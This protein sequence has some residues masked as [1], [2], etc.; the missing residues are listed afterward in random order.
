MKREEST[1]RIGVITRREYNWLKSF[2]ELDPEEQKKIEAFDELQKKGRPNIAD[3]SLKSSE[4]KGCKKIEISKR[5]VWNGFKMWYK[6]ET[7]REFV[8]T[9]DSL[10]NI[11]PII[12][13][14]VLDDDFFNCDRLVKD[15]NVPSFKK[16]L[17]IVGMYGNGKSTIMRTLSKMF[18]HYQ[19]PMS[20][21][22]V[23]A[24]DLV[25]EFESISTQG[26]KCLFYERYACKSLYMDDVKKEDKASNF[27]TKEIVK[28]I[29][30]KRYDKGLKTHITCNY[31]EGDSSENVRDA[32]QEF[33]R[34]GSH[35]YDRIFEMFNIIQFKGESLR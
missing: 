10:K 23:N 17:L 32:L 6:L 28:S 18:K 34:Y 15:M 11:E 1:K 9:A 24:H 22:S 21:K 8:E 3:T 5:T 30:E 33:S 7:G 25:T 20:F 13:Y 4:E 12:K 31:R 27:G 2:K 26:G 29:L 16:G 19:M 14:F 35:I